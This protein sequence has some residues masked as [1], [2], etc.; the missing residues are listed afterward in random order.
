MAEST[1]LAAGKLRERVTFQKRSAQADDGYGNT[2]TAF[3]DVMT[4]WAGV[5][6]L[7]GGEEIM[8]ARLQGTQPVVITV[9]YS[10]QTVA[11]T[12]EWRAVDARTGTVY[13][14]RTAV[15]DARKAQIDMICEAGAPT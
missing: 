3:A 4:V 5:A 10:S 9:R 15:A 12:P 1:M 11:V 6:P 13:N 2:L 8:A 14:I 7:R